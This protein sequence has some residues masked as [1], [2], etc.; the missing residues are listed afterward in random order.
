MRELNDT[1]ID[2]LKY[3]SLSSSNTNNA[4]LYL[5]IQYIP[6]PPLQAQSGNNDTYWKIGAGHEEADPHPLQPD[7]KIFI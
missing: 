3:I 2:S 6:I 1:I 5:H 7:C 4:L